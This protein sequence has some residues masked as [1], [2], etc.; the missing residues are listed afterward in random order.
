MSRRRQVVHSDSQAGVSSLRVLGGGAN[1]FCASEDPGGEPTL[2]ANSG[3][4]AQGV[5]MRIAPI[6]VVSTVDF[7][8]CYVSAVIG[9]VGTR[10]P[11]EPPV[12]EYWLQYQSL[13]GAMAGMWSPW[14]NVPA[15]PAT[16]T[17]V[18]WSQVP[19]GCQV[20][21]HSAAAGGTIFQLSS[22]PE[23]GES[24][25]SNSILPLEL[26]APTR[27]RIGVQGTGFLPASTVNLN[28][29]GVGE[30]QSTWYPWVTYDYW[31]ETVFER[32][33]HWKEGTMGDAPAANRRAT[34]TFP[35]Q[36]DIDRVEVV[37]QTS[38]DM[39]FVIVLSGLYDE[40][41][42][43]DFDVPS[44]GVVW[45]HEPTVPPTTGTESWHYLWVDI[46][47]HPESVGIRDP[48]DSEATIKF[49]L[50]AT[51]AWSSCPDTWPGSPGNEVGFVSYPRDL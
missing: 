48:R 36:L 21:I 27:I 39:R 12:S 40:T 6:R 25:E 19:A 9:R 28:I 5:E 18:T 44:G 2:L 1:I 14:L 49:R 33:I 7:Q 24:N 47:E 16:L 3:V 11:T 50:H 10:T 37:A 29:Q 26:D 22:L 45:S 43:D 35:S 8:R 23:S 31:L 42:R 4:V 15:S 30:A 38:S 20:Q 13:N 51:N 32:Y 41:A 17:S 34:L 46:Y